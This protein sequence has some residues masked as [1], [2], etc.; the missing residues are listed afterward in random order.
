MKKLLSVFLTLAMVV[1]LLPSGMQF[2]S[3]EQSGDYTY[4]VI[5]DKAKITDYTGTGTVITIPET[6]GDYPVTV[7]GAWAFAYCNTLTSVTIPNSVVSLEN[8]AFYWC[9][10]M[11]AVNLG[12]GVSA[13]GIYV[14][15]GC[16]KLAQINVAGGNTFFSSDAGVLFNTDKTTLVQFPPGKTGAYTVPSSVTTIAA[17]SFRNCTL[18]SSVSIGAGVVSIGSNAFAGCSALTQI[19][20]D[21]ANA[22]YTSLN[23]VLFNAGSTVLIQYPAGKSGGYT[24]PGTVATIGDFAFSNTLNLTSIVLPESL[25]SIGASAFYYCQKLT[26][27]IIPDNVIQIGRY[28]FSVCTGVTDLTIG[29][30]VQTIGNDAFNYCQKITSVTIPDS[31]VSI[32]G[33]AFT[34]CKALET[35]AIGTGLVALGERPFGN[36]EALTGFSV[37]PANGSFFSLEGVLFDKEQKNLIR[38]PTVKS[39][40]YTV[41]AGVETLDS[42]SFES[43]RSLTRIEMPASVSVI[44]NSAFVWC[45]NLNLAIIRNDSAVFGEDVFEGCTSAM[46]VGYGSSTTQTYAFA[47]D[48]AFVPLTTGIFVLRLPEKTMYQKGEAFVSDG[49][50]VMFVDND[51]HIDAVTSFTVDGFNADS[52]GPQTLTV[53]YNGFETFFDITVT[54]ISSDHPYQNNTNQSWTYVHP[55]PADFLAVTFSAQT[56]TE[57]DCDYIY[58]FDAAENN[59]GAFSGDQLQNKTVLLPGNS[60]RIQLTSDYSQ[61]EYGFDII[62][63]VEVST[64]LSSS[65]PYDNDMDESWSYTHPEQANKLKVTFSDQTSVEEGY[66]FIYIYDSNDDLVGTYTG[67]ML[68]GRTL[69]VDGNS[70]RIRLTS[71]GSETAYGFDIVSV[72][73]FDSVIS[74]D[75]PY[76]NDVDISWYYE[77]PATVTYLELTF[78]PETSLEDGY[79][80]IFIY[81]EDDELVGAFT[82]LELAGATKTVFGSSF[83]IQLTSDGSQTDYGFDILTVTGFGTSG[84]LLTPAEGSG[85]VVDSDNGYIY[86][87]ATGIISLNGYVE[88]PEGYTLE[89]EPTP[90]GLGTGAVVNVRNSLTEEIVETY[91]VIIFGDINGDGNIDSADAGKVVDVENY[92]FSWDPVAD[93]AYRMAGDVNADGNTDSTDAGAF[94]DCEN[95]KVTIDQSTGIA[96]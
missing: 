1:V 15:T 74:S 40:A 84:L 16:S 63:I 4:T 31:V 44:N 29:S 59:M 93:A 64:V 60:F 85:C 14:F 7:I 22:A 80:Y 68:A 8:Y 47:N 91:T 6:L 26:E 37:D 11:T 3:A 28:A 41:P 94:V 18:V 33:N 81:D 65:H 36:C 21:P 54:F 88:I 96:S 86:G 48:L 87:L 43:S 50:Q 55:E 61:T 13:I 27:V 30:S 9:S 76:H 95:Y 12:T 90:F 42:Y 52:Y 78:S 35:V 53:S 24:V 5:E 67:D 89:I 20:V 71:D 46:L 10:K 17:E 72:E 82:G 58:L 34:W 38:Y 77:H 2:A 39:G 62:S 92:L 83:T 79:D 73:S 57:E 25:T 49:M 69:I 66:D 51:L 56:Y 23:G 19:S 45:E 32:G 70:F 75:H